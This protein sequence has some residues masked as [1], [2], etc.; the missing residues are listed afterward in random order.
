MFHPKQNQPYMNLP[1]THVVFFLIYCGALSVALQG[2]Q[3]LCG[4]QSSCDVK[5]LCSLNDSGLWL[6][7][8]PFNDSSFFHI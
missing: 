5:E 3:C 6:C 1:L 7:C 2:L 8:F 4:L